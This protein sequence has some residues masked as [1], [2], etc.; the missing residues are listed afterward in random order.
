MSPLKIMFSCIFFSVIIPTSQATAQEYQYVI[1]VDIVQRSLSLLVIKN[2]TENEIK[3]YP[4]AVPINDY[5]YPL[6]SI[7]DV[8]KIEFNP[9]WY[10]TEGTR[11]AYF[12]K[13][14]VELPAIIKP[15]DPRNAM[16][17]V[18]IFVRLNSVNMP[19]R[20]HGTNDQSSIGKKI[21][22]GCIRLLNEDVIEL[23]KNI[24]NTKTKIV[25]KNNTSWLGVFIIERSLW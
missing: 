7:G 25:F 6:I 10:P 15:D 8:I 23:A 24:Q 14:G 18:K 5:I 3:K 20:I 19:I 9:F 11:E 1:A 22:R 21:T 17:K 16:G 13:Y 12:K 4:I 2:G